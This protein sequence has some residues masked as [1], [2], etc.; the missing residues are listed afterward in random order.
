MWSVLL[1]GVGACPLGGVVQVGLVW[2]RSRC[3]VLALGL[4]YSFL[5]QKDVDVKV[6]V[7]NR[8]SHWGLVVLCRFLPLSA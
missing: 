5:D 2:L 8:G 3:W 1:T 7:L 6:E 4:A